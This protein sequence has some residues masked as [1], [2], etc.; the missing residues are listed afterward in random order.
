MLPFNPPD[1]LEDDDM[2]PIGPVAKFQ[3]VEDVAPQG[4]A[5]KH[6]VSV[7]QS[8][9]IAEDQMN[10]MMEAME[11]LL[12]KKLHGIRKDNTEMSEKWKE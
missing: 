4:Q 2:A 8:E 5:A 9:K 6:P 11:K 7:S 1:D 12:N 3:K 10:K